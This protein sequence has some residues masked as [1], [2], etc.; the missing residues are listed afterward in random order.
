MKE[1]VSRSKKKFN[2]KK[3]KLQQFEYFNVDEFRDRM[4]GII[5]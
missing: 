3:T 4:Y 2:T 1:K 5:L